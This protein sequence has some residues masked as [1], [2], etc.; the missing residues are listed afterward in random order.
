MKEWEGKSERQAP[1][2]LH[3][4]PRLF[5]RAGWRHSSRRRSSR[6]RRAIDDRARGERPGVSACFHSATRKRRLPFRPSGGRN[7][8][9]PPELMKEEKPQGDF[10][11]QEERRLFY[12]ALTRAKRQLTLSTIV[13]KR[14]KPSPFLDDFL[15]NPQIQKLD[16]VQST[17]KVQLPASEEASGPTA[18][19]NDAARLFPPMTDNS[20][21]YSRVALWA[22]AFHPPRP[23]PLQLSASAIDSYERCP[24]QYLFQHRLAHSRGGARAIDVWKCD[25]HD[26]EGIRRRS[27]KTKNRSARRVFWQFTTAS[28]CHRV[29][30]T[31]ITKRNIGRPGASNWKLFIRHIQ[32][33][34]R[35]RAASGET[36]SSCRC[37]GDVVITGRMDQVN[38]TRGRHNRDRGLQNGKA[39]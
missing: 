22:K 3:R 13:N 8:S 32:R 36:A 34:S 2:R 21:A 9:F 27:E 15:M 23:E 17:P 18:A 26:D 25:A 4:I 37:D 14:K 10:Q 30:P 29:S 12:V 38:R 16:A 24:M 20:R 6:R 19:S 39:A 1:A 5:R 33:R 35:G 31:N 28:G 11:I 7:S